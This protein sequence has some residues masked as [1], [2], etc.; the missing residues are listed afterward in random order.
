MSY[1]SRIDRLPPEARH[2]IADM[3]LHYSREML[4]VALDAIR[5]DGLYEDEALHEKALRAEE[6]LHDL[7]HEVRVMAGVVGD[8]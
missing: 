4:F 1:Y 6:A 3:A 5:E 7:H 8:E 2:L